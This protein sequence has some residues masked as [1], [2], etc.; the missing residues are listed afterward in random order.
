[1]LLNVN[2]W[3][4]KA[5]YLPPEDSTAEA[6]DEYNNLVDF[7]YDR[8]RYDPINFFDSALKS[9]KGEKVKPKK[10][11]S[12]ALEEI[13]DIEWEDN[14]FV[15]RIISN[16]DEI[17]MMLTPK[18]AAALERIHTWFSKK[19]EEVE[20]LYHD[21]NSD[22]DMEAINNRRE[23]L[24]EIARDARDQLDNL[25]ESI[26]VAQRHLAD[27]SFVCAIKAAT[28]LGKLSGYINSVVNMPF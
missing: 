8:Y 11:D 10:I 21:K 26:F 28:K 7:E 24:H 23:C 27:E 5:M 4:D 6:I 1:M 18:Y 16:I 19:T 3:R 20:E 13:T 15:D 25:A 12:L 2:Y 9:I 17:E 22:P 14:C